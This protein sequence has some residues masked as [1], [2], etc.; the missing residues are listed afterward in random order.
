MQSVIPTSEYVHPVRLPWRDIMADLWE[1][2]VAYSRQAE[3]IGVEWSTY[4]R[5][6]RGTEPKHSYACAI[7][8]LHTQKCGA[9]LTQLRYQQGVTLG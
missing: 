4:Q 6:M 5:W 7:L 9:Q 8:A 2:H 3:L 1:A